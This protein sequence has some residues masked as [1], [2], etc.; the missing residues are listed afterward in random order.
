[1]ANVNQVSF[2]APNAD[3]ATQQMELQRK[4]AIIDALKKSALTPIESQQVSG[5][6]VPISPWEGIAKLAQAGVAGYSEKKND[7]KE[8]AL[9]T[10]AQKRQA[11]ALRALAPAG[12]FEPEK[13]AYAGP[14]AAQQTPANGSLSPELKNAWAKAISIYQ[15]NPELGA[16]LIKN[17]AEMTPEQKN[18]AAMGQDPQLMGALGKAKAR[19][20]GI[21]EMQP[22]STAIDL[23]N[24]QKMVAPDFKSGTAGGFDLQGNPTMAGIPGNGVISQLAGQQAGAVEGAKLP[25]QPPTQVNTPQGPK[26]MTPAQQINAANGQG[27]MPLQTPQ[28]QK[29]ADAQAGTAAT[30][31]A[32]LNERVRS[33]SDL[34]QRIGESRDAMTKFKAGAGKETRLQVAQMAQAIGLP[35]ATVG[36]IAGGDIGAMQEF[37][38]LAVSQAMEALKQT[39]ATDNGMGGRMTQAEFQQF[40]K[41]NPN[42]STD[43]RAINKLFDFSEKVHSRN[44]QEQQ[45]F[46][47][48]VTGGGEPARWPAEWSRIMTGNVGP[49]TPEAAV[50]SPEID[51][52]LKKYGGQ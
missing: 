15:T 18:M 41:V 16:P 24:N 32:A 34:M 20:E 38:K 47:K 45:A 36:K 44:M 2:G 52:L 23:S 50:K 8:V 6:V 13:P 29:F 12:T 3:L 28:A 4:Q 1:M 19:K 5:R 17:L 46:D 30:A 43:P 7:E 10:E 9:H 33:G 39:M 26:L 40:L 35:D 51:D 49:S 21:L 48:Y 25:F 14:M 37:Q 31:A 11:A 42:L 27:G 22:N